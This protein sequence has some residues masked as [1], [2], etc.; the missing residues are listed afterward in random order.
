MGSFCV[1]R[2]NLTHHLTDPTRPDPV[3]LTNLTAWCHQVL[4]DRPLMHWRSP[5]KFL[6]PC[7]LSTPIQPT[8]NWKISTQLDPTQLMGQP[9]LWTTVVHSRRTELNCR[10]STSWRWRT[11]PI[12]RRVTGSTWCRSVRF[13]LA[14][15]NTVIEK[16]AFSTPVR[17][18]QFSS[19]AVNLPSCS[20][21]KTS[22]C[23]FS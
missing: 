15:V 2:S 7:Y 8:K 16:Q 6:V 17:E 12:T 23:S 22:A 13:S 20:P 19:S 9:N 4:S 14:A 5:F 10:K 18:L 1:T 3:Q 21:V 11:W